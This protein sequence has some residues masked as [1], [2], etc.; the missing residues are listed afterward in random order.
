M[1][2]GR[3][4]QRVT[5][6]ARHK[7][8]VIAWRDASYTPHRHLDL[9]ATVQH[10]LRLAEFAETRYQVVGLQLCRL[11]YVFDFSDILRLVVTC[12]R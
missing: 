6:G 5:A 12:R 10:A 3:V 7:P 9:L 11:P 8:V 4:Q 1:V 2:R